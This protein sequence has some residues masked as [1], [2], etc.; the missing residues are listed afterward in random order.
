MKLWIKVLRDEQF[1]SMTPAQRYVW[2]GLLVLA[3][4]NHFP[5]KICITEDMGYQPE[6]IAKMLS[7]PVSSLNE[8][9]DKMKSSIKLIPNGI[10][11]IL[12]WANYQSEYQR[13]KPYREGYKAKLQSK[14][15]GQ[16]AVKSNTLEGEGDV[17]VDGENTKIQP[18][19]DSAKVAKPASEAQENIRYIVLAY[20]V[21]SGHEFE[22][23]AWDKLNF[24][25]CAKSA[26][27][28]FD[29]FGNRRD[30]V[31]CIDDVSTDFEKKGLSWTLETV[32]KWASDYKIKK[33]KMNV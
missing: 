26:K 23:K 4:D 21:K 30:A 8:T 1:M 16:G 24:A 14:V 17:E 25:R 32:C 27:K 28:L 12:N 33:E 2:L 3:G 10:I 29:Y 13:Q 31:K 6:Q 7:V 9:L 15:T 20:K 22:D 5:G 11:E 19:G 18:I